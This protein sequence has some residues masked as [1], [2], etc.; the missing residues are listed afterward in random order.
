MYGTP[1]R[2]HFEI[3][4]DDANIERLTG[5]R[6]MTFPT[7]GNGRTDAVYGAMW[8]TLPQGTQFFATQPPT[9]G[10]VPPPAHTAPADGLKVRLV[11]VRGGAFV[12]S[13]QLDQSGGPTRAAW[14]A[15]G[16]GYVETDFEYEL[17]AT[18]SHRYPHSP[19]AGYE[20]LRFGRVL[21]PDSL[22]P[23][24]APHWRQVHYTNT[25]IG[26]VNLNAA[27]IQ[28]YS[29]ADFP[30]WWLV[31]ASSSAD[32]RCRDPRVFGPLDWTH[33]G[34]VESR[35]EAQTALS[36]PGVQKQLGLRICKFPT[37]WD[38]STFERRFEWLKTDPKVK[39]NGRDFA[40]LK[41][42]A[43]ALCFWQQ[44]QVGID[45]IH[46]HFHPKAFIRHFRNCGWLSLDEI[47]Q[48]MPR[49][50][51][52]KGNLS[53]GTPGVAGK[54]ILFSTA[55]QRFRPYLLALNQVFR[56]YNILDAQRQTHFLSQTYTENVLWTATR[57]FGQGHNHDYGAFY[58]RGSMQLTWAGNYALYGA[59]RQF[60][61]LPSNGSYRNLA[62]TH[63][64]VHDWGPPDKQGHHDRRVWFPGY[65]PEIVADGAFELC[66]SGGF[67]WVSKHHAGHI[68][69]NRIA[70]LELNTASVARVSVLVNGG[71]NGFA[72]RQGF[73]KYIDRYRGDGTDTIP[74]ETFSVTH[75]SDSHIV[76]V[77]YTPQRP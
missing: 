17:Y 77:D 75:H 35:T 52:A 11:L 23:P 53:S 8:F 15:L 47:A 66:D 29:D 74:T 1:N 30:N 56:R 40:R 4:C 39:M 68:N 45:P 18:A 76:F 37:E 54:S 71:G 58:G 50:P 41:A 55:Q 59:F 64:S 70:D 43:S 9:N 48:L 61:S 2:I 33:D 73:A 44:A 16:R 14:R 31:D 19:S 42:H 12:Q 57:E 46:W 65:D 36:D 60:A 10:P 38:G 27:N 13:Y 63:T 20:L 34:I 67:F 26:W 72:D 6:T 22:S 49:R 5:R 7:T 32:S 28:K 25:S 51:V 69:I 21:G 3:V 24:S 62:I